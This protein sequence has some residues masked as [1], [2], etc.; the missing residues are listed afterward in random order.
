MLPASTHPACVVRSRPAT[1]EAEA[2][3][4]TQVARGAT[5]RGVALH[6]A[7][8]AAR[9]RAAGCIAPDEEARELHHAAPD[10]RT[11]ATWLKRREQGEPLAW[12]IGRFE[13]CGLQ[14]QVDPGVYVPRAQS[15]GL[16]R[17]A[18]AWLPDDGRAADICTGTGA[19]AAFMAGEVPNA[20][21]LAVDVE[22]GAVACA[23][24]NGVHVV[25]G[26][27]YAPLG[28]EHSFDVITAVPPYVPTDEIRLLPADVQRFE[29]LLALDGG[30][31]GLDIARRIVAGAADMLVRGGRLFIEVGGDQDEALAPA[32]AAAGFREAESW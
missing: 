8:V 4:P 14:L 17:H 18:V 30:P 20:S 9:L 5:L 7:D 12:I 29:P 11:L 3:L 15:E 31:D 21:V 27:L 32:L 16:A 23:L 24:R 26:D 13:F 6:A 28:P 25:E 19:I 2:G 10:E 22:P 1:R